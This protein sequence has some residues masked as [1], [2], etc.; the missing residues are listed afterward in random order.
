MSNHEHAAPLGVVQ[1]SLH[2]EQFHCLRW[3]TCQELDQRL[4]E[5]TASLTQ[6]DGEGGERKN[7]REKRKAV[8]NNDLDS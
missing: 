6:E 4:S 8:E 3:V 7:I 1:R 5:W 2:H